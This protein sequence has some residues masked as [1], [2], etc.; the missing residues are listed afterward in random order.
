M[1][2]IA[3]KLFQLAKSA[4]EKAYCPFSNYPVG[5]ALR[6]PQGEYYQG[7]NVESA[8]YGLTVCAER[9]AI[10]N[11]L[12]QGAEEFSHLGIYSRDVSSPCG[13]CRQVIWDICGN[14]E[15][16]SFDKAGNMNKYKSSGL[17]PDP[18]QLNEE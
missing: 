2:E 9:N 17:L 13:A 5:A 16:Y 18:F 4:S 8:S 10:S 7:C 6:S 11:A 1:D 12:I 14:I 15:I 3:E